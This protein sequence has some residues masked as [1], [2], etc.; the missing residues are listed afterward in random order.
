MSEELAPIKIQTV[1]QPKIDASVSGDAPIT[2]P[3]RTMPPDVVEAVLGYLNAERSEVSPDE[4]K[5]VYDYVVDKSPTASSEDI[6]FTLFALTSKL[7]ASKKSLFKQVFDV[8]QKVAQKRDVTSTVKQAQR[9]LKKE[10]PVLEKQ[11]QKTGDWRF[12]LRAVEKKAKL[13]EILR[14]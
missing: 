8:S 6:R 11:A 2:L 5:A 12:Y 7:P 9:V 10:I 3:G 13:D 4:L 1:A 14:S